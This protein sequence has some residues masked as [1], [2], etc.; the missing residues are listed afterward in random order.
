LLAIVNDFPLGNADKGEVMSVSDGYE[1]VLVTFDY[2]AGW[3][4]KQLARLLAMTPDISIECVEGVHKYFADRHEAWEF[5]L[6]RDRE[7]FD[8]PVPRSRSLYVGKVSDGRWVEY[9][10]FCMT[11]P[12]S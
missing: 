1:V 5:W 3:F 2:D 9:E 6:C 11:L 12:V 4:R 10:S 7:I 8:R